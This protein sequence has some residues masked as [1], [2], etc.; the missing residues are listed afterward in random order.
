MEDVQNCEMGE[1]LA[2]LNSVPKLCMAM[3]LWKAYN[4]CSNFSVDCKIT[5]WQPNKNVH[6][7]FSLTAIT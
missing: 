2:S 3:D 4:F 6:L 1:T 7:A 5:T